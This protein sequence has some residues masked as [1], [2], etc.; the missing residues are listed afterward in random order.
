MLKKY[1]RI[2]TLTSL[3]FLSHAAMAGIY[4]GGGGGFSAPENA[5]NLPG[6]NSSNE[7]YTYN[8][9]LG[10]QYNFDQHFAS[11]VEAN[12]INYGK[13]D[14]SP[15]QSNGVSGSFTNSAIQLLITGTYIMDNGVNTFVKA[16]AAHQM[17]N[18]S[19]T[20]G[21][22]DISSWIPDVAGGVGYYVL[23]NL[24]LYVQYQHSFGSNW[25]NASAGNS[26]NEPV[27]MDTLTAG[28]TYLLPM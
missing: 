5:P 17:S 18:L 21:S 12:Y 24:N 22:A 20:N 11:G 7:Q 1:K 16:G 23:K 10:Y 8:A 15:N 26:P 19:I 3:L 6:T 4:I 27:T 2:L 13:T 25:N 28:V 14:Y 9:G